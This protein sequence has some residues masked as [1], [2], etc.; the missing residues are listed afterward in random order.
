MVT[1]IYPQANNHCPKDKVN[2]FIRP[3]T[4]FH[5]RDVRHRKHAGITLGVYWGRTS[6]GIAY[7]LNKEQTDILATFKTPI[8]EYRIVDTQVKDSVY[9]IGFVMYE[10]QTTINIWDSVKTFEPNTLYA[11]YSYIQLPLEITYDFLKYENLSLYLKGK[12]T[13]IL[14]QKREVN[15]I[16]SYEKYDFIYYNERQI[17]YYLLYDLGIGTN[18]NLFQFTKAS[19]TKTNPPFKTISLFIDFNV[20]TNYKFTQSDNKFNLYVSSGIMFYMF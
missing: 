17:T 13:L 6:L 10:V 9:Y 3:Y 7:Q 20:G 11:T 19:T 1:K 16:P 5:I 12:A 18:I 4:N 15:E 2:I 14:E 8:K